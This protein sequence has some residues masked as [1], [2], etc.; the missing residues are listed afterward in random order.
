MRKIFLLAILFTFFSQLSQAQILCSPNGN[1]I[2]Y[3]NYDG[4]VLNINVDVNMPNIKIGIVSYEA[5]EVN[6]SGAFVNNVTAVH[7]AGYNS[8]NNNCGGA[9]VPVTVINGAPVGVTPVIVYSPASPL[10]NANGNPNIICGY[11]CDTA[12]YQGGCN[13]V[14]QINAYFM[15]QFPGTLLRFHKI[16]YGCWTGSPQT[17]SGAGNCCLIPAGNPLLLTTVVTPPSCN[18]SCDAS[19][20][21]VATGGTPPYGYQWIGG[22]ATA[23]YSNLCP[24]TYTVIVADAAANSAMQSVTI[25]NPPPIA[26]TLTQ[27]ACFSYTFNGNVITTS[28]LYKDTLPSANGCD[29]II[30]LN[31][32]I[33]TVN[34]AITQTGATLTAVAG[35]TYKWLNCTTNTLIPGALAQSYTPTVS[36]NYA[37]IVTANGCTDTSVCKNVVVT[38]IENINENTLISVFPNPVSNELFIDIDAQFIGKNCLIYDAIGQVVYMQKLNGTSNKL[39]VNALSKGMYIIAIDGVHKKWKVQK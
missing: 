3:T 6:L 36:G 16:Q 19:V 2:L 13:T 26:T 17:L 18:G 12:I 37:V 39:P 29:S 10:A 31:L 8:N 33:N 25:N 30:N 21:A 35:Y 24:G 32:T 27:T 1:L 11:S 7:F 38:G 28:G 22:P 34:N 14:D 4:G 20:I 9:P 15:Q 23:T 5:V